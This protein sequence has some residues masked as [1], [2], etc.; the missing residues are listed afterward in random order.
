MP[1]L[2]AFLTVMWSCCGSVVFPAVPD[3]SGHLQKPGPGRPGQAG[4]PVF[5]I[6]LPFLRVLM[7]PSARDHKMA[8]QDAAQAQTQDEALRAPY[9]RRPPGTAPR[10]S[11]PS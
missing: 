10:T 5:T 6:V 11:S 1:L 9:R 8:D 3:H 2:H 4:W 7:H